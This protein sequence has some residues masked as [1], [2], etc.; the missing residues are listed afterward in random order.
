MSPHSNP[1]IS[2]IDVTG[3]MANFFEN[4]ETLTQNRDRIYGEKNFQIW[5]P[6]NWRTDAEHINEILCRETEELDRLQN[7]QLG[8]YLAELE[9]E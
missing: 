6:V 3:E 4:S 7:Q 9:N 8:D 1:N 2:E 5:K